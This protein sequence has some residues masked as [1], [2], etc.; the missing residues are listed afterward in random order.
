MAKGNSKILTAEQEI[1]LRQPIE[2]YVGKI[3]TK[4]DSLRV[5][6]I[7]KVISLQNKIDS[8]KRDRN[9]T[10]EEKEAEI[11]KIRTELEKAKTV[12]A[13]HKD[14]ISKLISDAEAYLKEHFDRDYYLPVKESCE[15]EKAAVQEKHRRRIAELE[16]QH[17]EI[18][19]KL[20]DHQEIKDEKY[21][22]KNRLFDAK[23]QL[24]KDL[25]QVKDRRHMAYN[26]KYHLID[27]LRMSKFTFIESRAQKWENYKYTFNR[28]AFLL[29][30]G[31]SGCAAWKPMWLWSI[32]RVQRF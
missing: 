16:K 7:D 18:M 5:D 23:M 11:A 1:Q 6:G 30:N 24:E 32:R 15:Q 31:L 13:K 8:V 20:T 25:Q 27:M 3:Q 28:R 29:A 17:Q 10:K 4:I 9:F 19:S 14:E 22:Y 2:D 12:D 21:V 26:Y